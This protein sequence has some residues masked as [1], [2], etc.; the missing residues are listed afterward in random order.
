[1]I[2]RIFISPKIR[3]NIFTFDEMILL[4]I[5]LIPISL[6]YG[7][8]IWF[9]N[10]CFDWRF[11]KSQ[12]F[13]IPIIS[14]G[15]IS[16]GGTGKTTH[17]E[18]IISLL[19]DFSSK[20]ILSRGYGRKTKG[21][22]T[23]VADSKVE[24]VGDEPLQYAQKFQNVSIAV[25]ED[26]S[27]GIKKLTKEGVDLIVLD[28]AFQ[29]RWV[30][31]GLNILLTNY[32]NLY[33][34][35]FLLPFGKLR[36]GRMSALRADVIVVTKTPKA[37][38]PVDKNR[39]IEQISPWPHQKLYFSYYNYSHPINIFT[40]EEEPLEEQ[41]I[42]LLT[43]IA[44]AQ[45]IKDYLIGKVEVINHL[46]YKDHHPY[47][48]KDVEKIIEIWEEIKSS[49]KLILTTHKDAVRL[50]EFK[51][52]LQ[53]LSICYLPVEVKFHEAEKFNDLV[54]SYVRENTRNS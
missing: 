7:L 42:L 1:V 30:Q 4:K 5:F 38:L 13:D 11:F 35:D 54:L 32:S 29:H 51:E 40:E 41:Q 28:D 20:A 25:Q 49:K 47:T 39:L 46:E 26:R 6:L 16:S 12:S 52:E 9:R 50:Q 15:N 23:V 34:D 43:G 45:S 36:E 14:V 24:E 33:I 44:D 48:S 3:H 17:V 19:N 21:F 53:N 27:Q 22:Q 8:L 31:P 18:Y 10:K 2:S 37:L